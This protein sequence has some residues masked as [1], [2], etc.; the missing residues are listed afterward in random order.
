M[1]ALL[2]VSD[3]HVGYKE[4]RRIVEEMRPSSGSDWLLVAGDVSEKVADIEWGGWGRGAAGEGV[5]VVR[6]EHERGAGND[7]HEQRGGAGGG[8]GR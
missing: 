8:T 7:R 1:T 3:L 6:G 2:A 4:N 5:V